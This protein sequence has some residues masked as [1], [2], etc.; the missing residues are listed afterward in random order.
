M[1]TA[2]GFIEAVRCWSDTLGLKVVSSSS[3][4]LDNSR[5]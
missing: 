3:S 2:G 5:A 1:V 4:L